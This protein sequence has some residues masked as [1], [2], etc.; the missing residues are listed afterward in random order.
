MRNGFSGRGVE[1]II[2]T[3]KIRTRDRLSES[4]TVGDKVLKVDLETGTVI[5]EIT[6]CELNGSYDSRISLKLDKEGRCILELSLQKAL[7]GHNIFGGISNL[8]LGLNVILTN[9]SKVVK[10]PP[11]EEWEVMRFDI[12]EVFI[13]EE[14]EKEISKLAKLYYPRRRK[15]IYE[16]G[17]YF[18]A[19]GSTLKIYAK[20]RE[21]MKHDYSRVKNKLG[22]MYAEQLAELSKK[23]LRVEIECRKKYIERNIGIID[24]YDVN[25]ELCNEIYEKEIM[26]LTKESGENMTSDEVL[27]KLIEYY[28]MG[29][30]NS[31]F[32]TWAKIQLLGT[33]EVR[34][35]M[36]KATYYR[37]LK[38]MRDIGISLYG[39]DEP[40]AW[41][42]PS[43]Y[44]DNRVTSEYL[45]C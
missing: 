10:L 31:I 1:G 6:S 16:G 14:P 41:W 15:H 35:T 20:Y 44:C 32:A 45:L 43:L 39:T 13:V 33:D 19:S 30:G 27:R 36:S 26:K 5:W 9:L 18:P 28:G 25:K 38:K 17:V 11:L 40:V 12:A 7:F 29:E 37:H 42:M 4:L 3:V 22:I 34:A 21:F 8:A 2:D 23:L 24:I